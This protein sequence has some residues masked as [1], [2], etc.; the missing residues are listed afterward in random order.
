ENFFFF[1]PYRLQ[2]S[3]SYSLNSN[4]FPV[5]IQVFNLSPPLP[6]T[7]A[8]PL[9][10][11]L[12]I[13]KARALKEAQSVLNRLEEAMPLLD[14]GVSS[15]ELLK[16]R[17]LSDSADKKTNETT[18]SI[19]KVDSTG[20]KVGF[21]EIPV[22]ERENEEL[23]AL[24]SASSLLEASDMLADVNEMLQQE[25][26]RL[27]DPL[28]ATEEPEETVAEEPVA[29]MEAEPEF[30]TESLEEKILAEAFLEGPQVAA[31]SQQIPEYNP[32]IQP[33]VFEQPL[34]VQQIQPKEEELIPQ[35]AAPEELFA[36][37]E[38]FNQSTLET[39]LELELKAALSEDN[40]N[41]MPL[42]VIQEP[43][44]EPEEIV[45]LVDERVLSRAL[46]KEDDGI[47]LDEEDLKIFSYFLPLAGMKSSIRQVVSGAASHLED[48]NKTYTFESNVL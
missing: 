8:G 22:L 44:L 9:T 26:N 2:V 30:F 14:A 34:E 24:Q 7:Q 16:E 32:L 11:E 12:Q 13:A 1:S 35:V 47:D 45:Q 40:V 15:T 31:E 43:V 48:N 27:S 17:Y 23:K 5:N 39:A 41:E 6:K 18:F 28:G 37:E 10:L 38:I 4:T 19:P 33:E 20:E 42:P 29:E 46:S 3:C 36:K 25:I 21:M